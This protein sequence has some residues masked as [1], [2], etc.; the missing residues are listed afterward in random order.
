MG[1]WL[2]PS[3]NSD[4]NI[5]RRSNKSIGTVSQIVSLLRQVSLGYYY[6]EIALM[7]R[8]TML[9]SQ[10]LFSS[11]IWINVTKKQIAKLTS[12]DESYFF[13]IFSLPRTVA[14]ESIYL[15]SGKLPVTFLVKFRRLMYYWHILHQPEKELISRVYRAQVLNIEKN[16]WAEQIQRDK[17]ELKICLSDSEV[18]RL[19]KNQ[20]KSYVTMKIESEVRKQLEEKRRVHSKSKFLN[21][22]QTKPQK[23]LC[24]NNLNIHEIQTLMKL[25]THML[26]EAKMNYKQSNGENI[27]CSICYLYPETQKHIFECFVIRR[28]AEK[29]NIQISDKCCYSFIGGNLEQQ[30]E[31][32]KIYIQL[33][34]LRQRI[35]ESRDKSPQEESRSTEDSDQSVNLDTLDATVDHLL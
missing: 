1:D 7:F 28:E 14:K 33:L 16:D 31:F 22:F 5:E 25:R 15:E 32:I 4:L 26:Y 12:S 17:T 10:L 23:Y 27:W 30:E 2:T 20:F 6:M 29:S 18:G 35:L 11:E 9:I 19:S 34:S 21:Q 8:D 13:N 3:I 24:S